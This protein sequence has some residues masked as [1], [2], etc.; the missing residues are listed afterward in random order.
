MP[1]KTI[2]EED[3]DV[4][5]AMREE[6]K[7]YA[8][9]AKAINKS[10]IAISNHCR[11]YDLGGRRAK[12][13]NT[14][15]HETF[16]DRFNEKYKDSFE[17]VSGYE[18]DKSNIEVM[19]KVCHRISTKYSNQALYKNIECQYCEA[20]KREDK[21]A[22]AEADAKHKAIQR[23]KRK[24]EALS[25]QRARELRLNKMC[26]ECG[27]SFK[28]NHVRTIYCSDDCKSRHFNR[29]K[30]LRRRNAIASGD[31]DADISL[32]R[33]A[34]LDNHIC[35]LCGTTCDANDFVISDDG[36]FI[37]GPKHPSIEHVKPLSKG[38]THTWDNVRL[39]H[40]YCNTIKSNN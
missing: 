31:I 15:N 34:A 16:I 17:Y 10:K 33:V 27:K 18:K 37:V 30:E 26:G 36:H 3:K 13:F 23:V 24:V 40:H 5:R 9:I 2:S 6:G 35:Y 1:V 20:D 11:R 8:E 29:S 22:K 14:N 28:A 38:G 19:C 21:R 39:A 12:D 32:E 25:K 4:I 7:G